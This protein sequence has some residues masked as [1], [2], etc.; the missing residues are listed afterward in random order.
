MKE[1]EIKVKEITQIGTVVSEKSSEMFIVVNGG[2]IYIK[3]IIK[4]IVKK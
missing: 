1:K 2:R 3:D 4:I